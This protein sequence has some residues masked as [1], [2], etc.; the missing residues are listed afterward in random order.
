MLDIYERLE[1]AGIGS[2]S[3]HTLYPRKDE[4]GQG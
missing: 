3:R 1:Q 4:T 2:P